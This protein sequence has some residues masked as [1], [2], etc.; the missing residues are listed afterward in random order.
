VCEGRGNERVGLIEGNAGHAYIFRWKQGR[1]AECGL[2]GPVT[3]S[4]RTS[5]QLAR[6]AATAV[7]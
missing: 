2:P 1:H 7:L 6:G 5:Y 3:G 4:R